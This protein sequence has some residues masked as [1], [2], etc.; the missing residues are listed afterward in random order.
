MGRFHYP[1]ERL[2]F[3]M[4]N[5]R[6]R[7]GSNLSPAQHRDQVAVEFL[8][9][10]P[11]TMKRWCNGALPIPPAVAMLAEVMNHWGITAAQIQRTMRGEPAIDAVTLLRHALMQ[12]R[13]ANELT[14]VMRHT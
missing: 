5:F 13:A 14:G 6:R 1:P 11:S 3:L 12:L 4:E 8:R 2:R 10:N 9:M 7:C